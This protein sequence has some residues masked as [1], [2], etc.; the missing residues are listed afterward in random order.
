[1]TGDSNTVTWPAADRPTPAT[2]VNGKGNI[3]QQQ[4]LN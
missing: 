2:T 3:V 1:V 4:K